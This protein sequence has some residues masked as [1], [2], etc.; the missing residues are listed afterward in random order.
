MSGFTFKTRKEY[1]RVKAMDRAEMEAYINEQKELTKRAIPLTN[2]VAIDL[3]RKK[4][5]DACLKELHTI[6]DAY[7]EQTLDGLNICLERAVA[8]T[9]GI[10]AKRAEELFNNLAEQEQLYR[11]EQVKA[12]EQMEEHLKQKGQEYE[13]NLEG[14]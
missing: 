7:V 1:K 3:A 8:Q 4:G 13:G 9:K 14:V 5:W 10:G 12:N 11:A 2:Q 6:L